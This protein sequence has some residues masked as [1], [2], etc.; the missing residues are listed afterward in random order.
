MTRDARNLLIEA[1]NLSV[2]DRAD[3]VAEL[4]ASLDGDVDPDVEAAWAEEIERRARDVLAG[5]G[6]GV[7]WDTFRRKLDPGQTQ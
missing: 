2:R 4:L 7:D 5:K 3:L 6:K 1:M